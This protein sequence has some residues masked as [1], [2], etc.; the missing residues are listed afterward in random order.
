M[1]LRIALYV[2]RFPGEAVQ[3]PPSLQYLAGYLLGHGLVSEEDLLFAN[4]A[5]EIV[6]FQ[7]HVLGVGS[8][9]QC[10]ADAVAVA[11]AVRQSLPECWTVIG[12]YHISAL[13]HTLPE[14]FDLGVMGEGEVTFAEIVALRRE[15]AAPP[16]H[17]LAG[18]RGLCYRGP[19]DQLLLTEKR[20]LVAD[21][22]LLPKPFRRLP[23]AVEW[24][25]LF[26]ARGCPY[27]C[28]YC[29][30]HQFWERYRPHSAE[31]VVDEVIRLV[32][33]F[34]ARTIYFVDDLFIAPKSRLIRIRDLLDQAGLLGKLSF[35]GFVRVNLVDEEVIAILAQMG[36]SEVRFGMETASQKLLDRIK[37][38][39]FRIEQA[40]QLIGLCTKY[41]IPVCAS[42]MFGIPGETRADIEETVTFWQR[43]RSSF[44]VAGF[45]L[46]QPVPGS[47][48][49]D[50]L[51]A[52]NPVPAGADFSSFCLDMSKPDFDWS[53]CGYYNEENI[54]LP[55]FR[56]LM[57]QIKGEFV[58]PAP[59][60]AASAS[61]VPALRRLR[62]RIELTIKGA[63]DR[64]GIDI[65]WKPR[66]YSKIPLCEGARLYLGCGEDAR[67][68]YLGCDV[69]DL[70]GVSV[71]CQ[72]WE[73]SRFCKNVREIY[74]RHMME[75]LTMPQFEATLADWH[76]ALADGGSIEIIVP[77][78]DFHMEQWQ[79]AVWDEAS[80]TRQ[81]SDARHV[82]A[83]IWGW[84]REAGTEHGDGS[85]GG[86]ALWD[87]HKCG[88]NE[89]S[90][91][92]FLT[93]AGFCDVETRIF[94][95]WHLV[96]RARKNRGGS[97]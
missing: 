37:D 55:E 87:V 90:I 7:P 68:G 27:K 54:P 53:R 21:I 72:A 47:R 64:C 39:P 92:F 70:P 2:T 86:A 50:E 29:A 80:W 40:E 82:F 51:Q 5:A 61:P 96:A 48:M 9:S 93:R 62:T 32:D 79:R 42:F 91:T 14:V 33:Q 60:A 3:T 26:T 97:R 12:G 46:M 22:D 18:I 41:R 73:V 10:F 85:A 56:D 89:K 65:R 58:A 71:V 16:A 94:E 78:M 13:P 31:Y 67:T 95:Q 25:Y 34:G 36:F 77:N 43:H 63:F 74:S 69:R 45:Y 52:V 59:A 75:H 17:A 81:F 1:K 88:F 57:E 83:S 20:E 8:V 84:Q 38:H 24:P 76:K 23:Y 30:S 66:S 28:S 15:H 6:A 35:H 44:R 49:W 19:D 11:R 4:S